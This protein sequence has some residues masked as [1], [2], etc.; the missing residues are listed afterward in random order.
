MSVKLPEHTGASVKGAQA[1]YKFRSIVD[2][3]LS[4]AF[5]VTPLDI[6]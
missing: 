5:A 4:I 1:N 6:R 3:A 2:P